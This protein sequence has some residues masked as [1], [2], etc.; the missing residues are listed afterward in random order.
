MTTVYHEINNIL[1]VYHEIN[2]GYYMPARGYEFY[3]RLVNSIS[4]K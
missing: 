3:L 1:H 2:R 4:H